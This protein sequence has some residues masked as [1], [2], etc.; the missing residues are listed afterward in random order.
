MGN[1]TDKLIAALDAGGGGTFFDDSQSASL[2]QTVLASASF[3]WNTGL[4]IAA[5]PVNGTLTIHIETQS[6]SFQ[7]TNGFDAG[8]A[9]IESRWDTPP[10]LPAG[11]PNADIFVSG[12][13]PLILG[14]LVNVSLNASSELVA[15]FTNSKGIDVQ[16]TLKLTVAPVVALPFSPVPT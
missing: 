8:F 9:R 11:L 14:L 5:L 2:D 16:L 4:V 10:A 15:D 13:A 6:T 7:N 3:S 1:K 12:T